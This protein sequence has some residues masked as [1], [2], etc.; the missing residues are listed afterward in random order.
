MY[1]EMY[2]NWAVWLEVALYLPC[3]PSNKENYSLYINGPFIIFSE[4]LSLGS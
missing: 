2:E 4:V 3:N 1:E